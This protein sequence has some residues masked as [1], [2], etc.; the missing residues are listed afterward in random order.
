MSLYRYWA[1]LWGFSMALVLIGGNL[2]S[3]QAQRTGAGDPR[4]PQRVAGVVFTQDTLSVDVRDEDFGAIFRDI[5]SQAQIEVG[6][7]DGLP[8]RRI[9]TQFTDLSLIEGLKRLLRVADVAGYALITAHTE[10]GV[11]IERILFLDAGAAP[12]IEPRATAAAPR[13]AARRARRVAARSQRVRSRTATPGPREKDS[14]SASV[15]EDLK[16]NPETERLLNQVVH[17]NEQVREQAIEGLMRL[18]SSSNKQRDL[19]EALE[20]YMDD[21]RHGDEETREEAR[22][23]IRA[24]LRR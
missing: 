7:L 1:G 21:L 17:P 3:A 2:S 20:P 14:A 23:D 8:A 4:P 11:K 15:F 12:G 22:E 19:M 13:M 6:N 16:A 24:M 9:S 10:D 18:A 5:A